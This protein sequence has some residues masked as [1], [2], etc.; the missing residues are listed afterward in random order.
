MI[1]ETIL[2]TGAGPNGITGRRIKES[3]ISEYE[4]L[5]PG[6]C[7]LDLSDTTAVDRFFKEH[8]IDYVIHCAVI[9]PSENNDPF[10]SNIDMF[11]N[12]A[13]HSS[14]FKKMF[15]LG[16][17][18]EYDKRR[19]I[20]DVSEN[21][22]GD[23]IPCDTYGLSKFIMNQ[24]ARNSNNIYNIRLFGTI[25]PYEPFTKN[26]I[27]N[28][29]LKAAK[30]MQLTLRQ[31]CR[32]SFTDIDDVIAFLKYALHK[33]LVYHDYNFVPNNTYFLSELA[34]MICRIA[35][36]DEH[37]NFSKGGINKEYT[38]S[39]DRIMNEFNDFTPIYRSLQKV[40]E[41]MNSVAL[42]VGIEEID[43]RWKSK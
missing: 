14:Y 41:R 1:R 12:L 10:S 15:Y 40:Y 17:G 25:N 35:N 3:L 11:F 32:F 31:D 13:R 2:I 27:S 39:G 43:A 4:I 19:S 18:A 16:S 5:S 26:V 28:L 34:K 38:G 8:P 30:R 9:Y 37:I 42:S 23:S 33:D 7:E 20:T 6:R 29:C 36:V 24:Y 22:I 21:L